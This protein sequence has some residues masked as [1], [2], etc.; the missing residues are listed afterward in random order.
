MEFGMQQSF[1]LRNKEESEEEKEEEKRMSRFYGSFTTLWIK[2]NSGPVICSGE[3]C[4]RI[5]KTF[6]S[7]FFNYSDTNDQCIADSG[8]NGFNG[9]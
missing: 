6:Q 2:W 7:E 3:E 4:A 8:T 9:S 1:C 5:C